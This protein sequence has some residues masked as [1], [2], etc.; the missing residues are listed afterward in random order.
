[1]KLKSILTL[2]LMLMASRAMA[3]IVIEGKV[4]VLEPTYLPG[5]ISFQMDSGTGAC[6]TG[7]W[8]RWQNPD[9]QNNKAVYSTLLVA[10][11]TGKKI[12][13]IMNDGETGCVGRYLHA[14]PY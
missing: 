14:L 8:L 1:M 13:F 6:P 12:R 3:I 5:F 4:T 2:F 10:L 7:T 9:P 11:A